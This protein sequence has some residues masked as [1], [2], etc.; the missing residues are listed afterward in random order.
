[1]FKEKDYIKK[2]FLNFQQFQNCLK[3]L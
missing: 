1:M 2:G 3:K